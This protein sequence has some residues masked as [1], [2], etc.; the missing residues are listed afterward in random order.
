MCLHVRKATREKGLFRNHGIVT[1]RK[2]KKK[3]PDV[4]WQAV[5]AHGIAGGGAVRLLE[6][7]R[8][9][10]VQARLAFLNAP[11]LLEPVRPARHAL[12]VLPVAKA[13]FLWGLTGKRKLF[14]HPERET[15]K[16]LG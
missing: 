12:G 1:R 6:A 16:T 4:P 10:A 11:V 5:P 13:T 9:G 3:S 15:G 8:H 2:K 14:R 7:V